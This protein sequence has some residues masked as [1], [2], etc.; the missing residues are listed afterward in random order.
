VCVYFQLEALQPPADA[1]LNEHDARG[2]EPVGEDRQRRLLAGEA[3][4]RSGGLGG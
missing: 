3:V 4:R 1:L 2:L